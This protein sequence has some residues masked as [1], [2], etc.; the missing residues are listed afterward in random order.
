MATPVKP[1]HL[2]DGISKA[3]NDNVLSITVKDSR[4]TKGDTVTFKIS[5]PDYRFSE[6]AEGT[7]L[8]VS[9]GYEET[10]LVNMGTFMIDEVEHDEQQA[11]F[12]T[13]KANAQF[14]HNNS[15]K[16]PRDKKYENKTLGAIFGE[17]AGR[18]GY[19]S[20]I[21]PKIAGIKV[22]HVVQKSQSDTAFATELAAK[23]DSFV[24]YQDGKMIVRSGDTT[25]GRV[26]IKKGTPTT[27]SAGGL[28]IDT[29]I[30]IASKR[31]VR[32]KYKSVKCPWRNMDQG[33]TKYETVG[34]GEPCYQISGTKVHTKDEAKQ[35]AGKKFAEL[36][37]GTKELKTVKLPG[38]P[39]IRAEM[40]L[41]TLNFHPNTNGNWIIEEVT[42]SYQSGG[43]YTTS[44]NKCEPKN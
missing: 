32:S 40:Q 36:E 24:K 35:L 39:N 17:I 37:R 5:N 31:K 9:L 41:I 6:P 10:G 8:T 18:N 3:A 42:H 23:Y 25:E 44:I 28:V 30:G 12:M 7:I 20:V 33:K 4:G 22:T 14:H 19:A 11:I 29:A 27:I 16:A 21:D 15:V 13:I 38:N 2:I 43:G 1:K 26:I 34:S